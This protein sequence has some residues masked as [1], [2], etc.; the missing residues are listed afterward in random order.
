MNICTLMQ[1]SL[2]EHFVGLAMFLEF[3]VVGK[4]SPFQSSKK[5]F[6]VENTVTLVKM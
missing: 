5:R 6:A 4:G 1:V 2:L 3:I